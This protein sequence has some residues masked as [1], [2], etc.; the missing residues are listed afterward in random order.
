MSR[1]FSFQS[2][3]GRESLHDVRRDCCHFLVANGTL[4][5][6][7]NEFGQII[8][9]VSDESLGRDKTSCV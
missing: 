1:W 7:L 8:L 4:R 9:K 6:M 3:S 5:A 2:L